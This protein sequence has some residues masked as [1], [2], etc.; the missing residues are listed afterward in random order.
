MGSR[1]AHTHRHACISAHT[2]RPPI[3]IRSQHMCSGGAYMCTA[4]GAQRRVPANTS[5][6]VHACTG[7]RPSGWALLALGEVG[8][9]SHLPQ[10]C[11][12][13]STA[14]PQRPLVFLPRLA[15]DAPSPAF[16]PPLSLDPSPALAEVESST[17][18]SRQTQLSRWDVP[19]A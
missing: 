12:A 15:T 13:A 16:S 19:V 5:T 18:P 14:V 17:Y 11:C 7:A 2:R 1:A 4:P 6:A 10:R 8:A 9:N 3:A